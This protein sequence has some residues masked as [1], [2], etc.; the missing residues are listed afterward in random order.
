MIIMNIAK[1]IISVA[2]VLFMAFSLAACGSEGTWIAKSGEKT[3]EPGVYIN[4]LIGAYSSAINQM[5]DQSQD[6]FTTKI[7][8][9]EGTE[10]DAKAW[11]IDQ[12]TTGVKRALALSNMMDELK[13]SFTEEELKSLSGSVDTQWQQYGT[14]FEK[15]GTNKDSYTEYAKY[16][17][18]ATKVFDGLYA[19]G[20][21]KEVS[22]ADLKAYFEGNFYRLKYIYISTSQLEEAAKTEIKTLFDS[23]VTRIQKGEDIDKVAKEEKARVTTETN[24]KAVTDAQTAV[25]E[26]QAAVTA[27][28]AKVAAAGSDSSAVTAAQTELTSAKTK[29][30]T[31][32]ATLK[33]AQEKV[34]AAPEETTEDSNVFIPK[35]DS[36]APEAIITFLGSAKAKDVKLIDISGE[37][38]LV[39]SLDIKEDTGYLAVDTQ[40]SYVLQIMKS[41]EFNDLIDEKI[42]EG[43]VQISQKNID[44]IDP[45]R[46]QEATATQS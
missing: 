46:I 18:M 22:D 25:T 14:V 40:R 32:Q 43:N 5:T 34:D 2:L 10:V 27:A 37:Y 1:R 36:T 33:S 21:T 45:K 6:V 15:M 3:I 26:A 39:Q 16:S 19:K 4:Y 12:A 23:Y 28:E 20:G 8:N 44:A 13:L 42:K 7:K 41:K 17:Q 9:T 35:V 24:K 38:Y 31:A 30:E 29:L 11:M